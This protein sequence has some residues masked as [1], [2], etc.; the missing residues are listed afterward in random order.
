MPAQTRIPPHS[1][2]CPTQS[3]SPPARS[4][5]PA[6][7]PAPAAHSHGSTPPANRPGR[8]GPDRETCRRA[9]PFSSPNQPQVD[10]C[11]HPSSI[12][13]S[14]IAPQQHEF[15]TGGPTLDILPA[16]CTPCAKAHA[17]LSSRSTQIISVREL[18]TLA[19]ARYHAR[20]SERGP[21]GELLGRGTRPASFDPEV[22]MDT[23]WRVRQ[24]TEAVLAVRIVGRF[25]PGNRR[26]G[27]G[28][29]ARGSRS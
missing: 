25:R 24:Q 3:R 28:G 22:T 12:Q 21:N 18:T 8:P 1:H 13:M 11:V 29:W 9:G 5:T 15:Q 20:D 2:S 6:H 10:A 17:R 27:D 7:P 19:S 14:S 16:N 26:L 23:T 4:S